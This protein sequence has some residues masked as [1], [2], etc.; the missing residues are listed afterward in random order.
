MSALGKPRNLFKLFKVKILQI[1]NFIMQ[2]MWHKVKIFL[3][4]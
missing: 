2:L 4:S 1:N 3:S